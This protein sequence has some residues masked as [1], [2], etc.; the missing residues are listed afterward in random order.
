MDEVL[1]CRKWGKQALVAATIIQK[2][3]NKKMKTPIQEV[4]EK[5]NS[6]TD[7]GFTAWMLNNYS[8]L[9]KRE[10]EMITDAYDAGRVDNRMYDNYEDYYNETYNTKRNE[11]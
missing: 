4:Y 3:N 9:L 10:K 2:S 8:D 6:M 1:T 5:F 7:A 11:N